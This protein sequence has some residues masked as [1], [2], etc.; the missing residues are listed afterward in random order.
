MV[1]SRTGTAG[2]AATA[3]ARLGGSSHRSRW[4]TNEQLPAAERL[5]GAAADAA[6]AGPP[7]PASPTAEHADAAKGAP[8]VGLILQ[9]DFQ[10][11]PAPPSGAYVIFSGAYKTQAAADHGACEA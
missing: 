4:R 9:R 7:R 10:V 5:R 6:G 2:G 8:H 1:T 3:A 11:T